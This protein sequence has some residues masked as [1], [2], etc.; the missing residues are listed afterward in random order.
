MCRLWQRWHN[1]RIRLAPASGRN[2]SNDWS[3][4]MDRYREGSEANIQYLIHL[5]MYPLT[6][7]V[8]CQSC[9]NITYLTSVVWFQPLAIL[10]GTRIPEPIK[11]QLKDGWGNPS[12]LLGVKVLL[13]KDS[14]LKLTPNP[15][16]LS[17]D[18]TGCAT[19]GKFSVSG[20]RWG[21]YDRTSEFI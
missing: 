17:T 20:K 5:V 2:S 9:F 7:I 15:G 19:F 21:H 18:E 16:V 4:R 3:S 13:G 14:G 12:P 1:K 10:S 8:N 11:V 6:F